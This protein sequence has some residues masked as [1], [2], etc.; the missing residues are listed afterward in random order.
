MIDA[1]SRHLLVTIL[2]EVASYLAAGGWNVLTSMPANPTPKDIIVTEVFPEEKTKGNIVAIGYYDMTE[3][4]PVE[5]GNSRLVK[6]TRTVMAS[7]V[8]MFENLAQSLASDIKQYFDTQEYIEY[9][10]ENGDVIGR[11]RVEDTDARRQFSTTPTEWRKYWW[12]VSATLEEIYDKG[13]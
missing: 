5:L 2:D 4:L 8:G 10:D 1:R 13:G 7:C 6:Q 9:R 11:V 3:P 12:V